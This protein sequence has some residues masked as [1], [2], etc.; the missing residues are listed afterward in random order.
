M[1]SLTRETQILH[2]PSQDIIQDYSSKLYSLIVSGE[3]ANLQILSMDYLKV[4]FERNFMIKSS[5]PL[6]YKPSIAEEIDLNEWKKSLRYDNTQVDNLLRDILMDFD[7]E[8]SPE[9][10]DWLKKDVGNLISLYEK[11]YNV[12]LEDYMRSILEALVI[13][14]AYDKICLKGR[15]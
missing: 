2:P 12:Q 5:K 13:R 7:I 15:I 14:M 3:D 10:I 8:S 11:K 1:S 6:L 9:N 4:F